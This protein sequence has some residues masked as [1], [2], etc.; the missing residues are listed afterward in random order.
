MSKRGCDVCALYFCFAFTLPTLLSPHTL[1]GFG[2]L[3]VLFI[4]GFGLTSVGAAAGCHGA[5]RTAQVS[6]VLLALFTHMLVL[7]ACKLFL[8]GL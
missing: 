1:L 7:P 6:P 5:G 3:T 8:N 4:S 2:S